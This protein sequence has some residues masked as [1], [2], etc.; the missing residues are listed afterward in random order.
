MLRLARR[1][2]VFARHS[3]E[4]NFYIERIRLL[5]GATILEA[6]APGSID[7]MVHGAQATVELLEKVALISSCLGTRRKRT[8][9]LLAISGHRRFGFDLAIAE[10][11][12]FLRSSARREPK[13]RG[14]PIHDTFVKR[15]NRCGFPALVRIGSASTGLS[16]RLQSAVSWL[17]ESRQEPAPE[18]AVV[19]SAIA[20]EALLIL[21]E[22]ESL[23]GPLSDRAAFI[24]ADD[25]SLRR[26][27]SKAVK[28]FY[29]NRSGIVHGGRRRGKVP[30][31]QLEGI[32]RLLV[33]LMVTL[34]SNAALW[35]TFDSVT[36]WVDEQ[37]WGASVSR[38]KRP[39]PASHLTRAVQLA[40]GQL[41]ATR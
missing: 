16:P 37:R 5:S 22:H 26:R 12:Q 20:L 38:I 6:F 4:N 15:F 30:P 25:A 10:G 32:D 39:F 21:N 8:Q 14:I 19:K 18:A 31:H 23:R 7:Q 24:L 9:D 34:A 13:P 17:F 29:D 33:L 35:P 40:D 41:A 28:G 36:N 11:F 1:R 2:N 3:W 27:I